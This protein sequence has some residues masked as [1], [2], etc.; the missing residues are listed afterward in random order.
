MVIMKQ[1]KER[2]ELTPDATIQQIVDAYDEA[3]KLL[4]SIGLQ[5]SQHREETLR[6]VCQQRKWSEVEVLNWVKKH[7]N[8]SNPIPQ[9]ENSE[10]IPANE[11]S[12]K[13]CSEYLKEKYITPVDNL[14]DEIEQNFLRVHKIHGNQYTWLK[15]MHWHYEKFSEALQMYHRFERETFLPAAQN[16]NSSRPATITHGMIKRL[17]KCFSVIERDQ[18]RLKRLI[19]KIR[20]KGNDFQNPPGACS[21]LCILNENFKLLQERLEAQFN[22]ESKQLIPRIEH[23]LG[24][25]S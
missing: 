24:K 20:K 1:V 12:L 11:E 13:K 15:N 8:G 25:A 22:F 17:E 23:E 7:T 2:E 10:A 14:L 9:N 21:T 6:S 19:D 5:P 3:D 18:E 16:L 4:A